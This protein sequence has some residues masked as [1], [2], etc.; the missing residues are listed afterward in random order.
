MIQSSSTSNN[1]KF[2]IPGYFYCFVY[3]WIFV[4][5]NEN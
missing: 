4:L 2:L 5:N 1:P 3:Y